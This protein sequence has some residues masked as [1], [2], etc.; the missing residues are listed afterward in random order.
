M[1][2]WM[3]QMSQLKQQLPSCSKPWVLHLLILLIQKLCHCR[4]SSR[5][6]RS[7]MEWT[8]SKW[9]MRTMRNYC[10]TFGSWS[11]KK[12]CGEIM[13]GR[14]K[15]RGTISLILDLYYILKSPLTK[16]SE[17]MYRPDKWDTH[18]QWY[19]TSCPCC[20]RPLDLEITMSSSVDENPW[21]PHHPR[22][23]GHAFVT[24]LWGAN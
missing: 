6:D 21:T 18:W 4:S 17:K 11:M 12:N 15:R 20:R 16:W 3:P 8:T 19:E 23:S 9:K 2:S 5:M 22:G 13:P 7:R 1:G 10:E 24:A 14:W